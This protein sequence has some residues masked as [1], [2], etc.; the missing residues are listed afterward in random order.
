MGISRFVVEENGYFI[1]KRGTD[2][3]KNVTALCAKE[4]K[5]I[6]LK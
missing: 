6:G 3:T 2:L 1:C 4:E 5:S